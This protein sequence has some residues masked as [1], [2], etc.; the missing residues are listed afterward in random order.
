MHT[1]ADGTNSATTA[2]TTDAKS[3]ELAT[4]IAR[5]LCRRATDA[6]A[7]NNRTSCK[8]PDET[9]R[10]SRNRP[11]GATA[12]GAATTAPIDALSLGDSVNARAA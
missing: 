11:H 12:S 9:T 7:T 4:T 3:A 5:R 2:A 1:T 10:A 6:I 8:E